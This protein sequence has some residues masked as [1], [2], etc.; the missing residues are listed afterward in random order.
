MKNL[1][2][3][4]L[5]FLSILTVGAAVFAFLYVDIKEPIPNHQQSIITIS[6]SDLKQV[7]QQSFQKSNP[8]LMKP[9]F[10]ETIA[11]DIL[12]TEED[13][14]LE[15]TILQLE[16]FFL[17]HPPKN[18]HLKHDG[19]SKS[20]KGSYLIGIYMDVMQ[21]EYRVTIGTKENLIHNIAIEEN[22]PLL[23]STR[24]MFYGN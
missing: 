2:R 14:D 3:S 23:W 13:L 9:Y 7:I 22:Q 18:F 19:V 12:E 1:T 17:I 8:S 4:L 5:I 6:T 16:D 20:G 15:E 24:Y 21:K 11:L 10:T